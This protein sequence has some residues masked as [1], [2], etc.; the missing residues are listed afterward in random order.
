IEL[1]T[2]DSVAGDPP[3]IGPNLAAADEPR[4]KAGNRLADAAL[5]VLVRVDLQ[6]LKDLGSHPAGARLVARE[7][8]A[9]D[10]LDVDA[11]LTQPGC[12]T[13][14]GRSSPDDEHFAVV[15]HQVPHKTGSGRSTSRNIAPSAPF[16]SAYW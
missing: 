6:H 14:P 12:A 11:E 7:R 9:I 4:V 16:G 5:T 3:V 8:L 2:T 13:R 10:D 15:L 1:A